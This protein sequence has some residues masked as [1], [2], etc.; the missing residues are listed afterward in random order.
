MVSMAMIVLY[1]V[2]N[3]KQECANKKVDHVTFAYLVTMV[4]NV[5]YYAHIVM[6]DYAIK[7][8]AAVPLDVKQAF[9][10]T[11]VMQLVLKTVT[12]HVT[13]KLEDVL[14]DVLRDTM[15]IIVTKVAQRIVQMINVAKLVVSVQMGVR[16]DGW[17]IHVQNVSYPL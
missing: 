15:E 7:Q 11:N 16:M 2:A 12:K 1:R 5:I 4:I 10:W 9:S 13:K 8:M 14:V 3:V 17:E 6:R